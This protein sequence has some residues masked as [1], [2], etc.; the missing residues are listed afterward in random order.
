MKYA[1]KIFFA[2][3]FL[4]LSLGACKKE[5]PA[6]A[7]LAFQALLEKNV[8]P[9]SKPPGLSLHIEAP[10]HGLSWA[11]A[12]GVSTSGTDR[13][14]KS[15]Q[16]YRISSITKTFVATSILLLYEKGHLQL[17]DPISQYISAEHNALLKEG[18]YDPDK[19]SIR[20]CLQH[21]SGLFDYARA[22]QY[23][24][25]AIA[26]TSKVWTRTE[27]LKGAMTWGAPFASPGDAYHYSDTGYNFL[28]EIIEHLTGKNLGIAVRELI[29]Y[30]RIGLRSTWWEKME[31]T[32]LNRLPL[33]SRYSG[34]RDVSP[35]DASVDLF[36]GGGIISTS[37][38]LAKFMYQLFNYG[39][40]TKKSTLEL[41]LSK[42]NLVEG[43]MPN[44]DYRMGLYKISIYGMEGYMHSGIWGTQLVYLPEYEAA[45]ALNHTNWGRYYVLKQ[46]ITLLGKYIKNDE[47]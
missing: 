40:F 21:T 37:T 12:A 28:G 34:K 46:V 6:S 5:I 41:M 45:I 30:E 31:A 26:D 1:P 9:F 16:A 44:K 24:E 2:Y 23:R 20:H 25:I 15:D 8:V 35:Y 38:D 14:V 4:L 7:P 39:I 17:D 29:G 27:Q 11:G 10:K 33:V 18:N 13:K 32:P 43:H 36:G 47:W 42:P 3:L 19:I 22:D